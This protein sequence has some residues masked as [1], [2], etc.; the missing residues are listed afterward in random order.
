MTASR[1]QVAR[2]AARTSRWTLFF[3]RF[4]GIDVF[5]HASL[6]LLVAVLGVAQAVT[7]GSI[8]AA[9]AS[10]LG[11]AA[12]FACVLLHEYGHALAARR[13]GIE[14]H[15][16]LL[17]PIGGVAQLDRMP[18]RPREELIVALA[19]PAVNLVIAAVTGTALIA[20]ALI[21]PPFAATITGGLVFLTAI[22]LLLL[23]FNLLPAFPMDGG[24]A[25]RAVLA[26]RMRPLRATEI[27]AK[28]GQFMAVGMGIVG[29][30]FNPLLAFV[31]LFVWFGAGKEVQF[32]RMQ[33]R[34]SGS[35]VESVMTTDFRTLS[36]TDRL[37][38][39]ADLS[40]RSAQGAFPVLHDG[41][42]VGMLGTERLAR[43]LAVG[44]VSSVSG[45][46]RYD[47][48]AVHPREQLV[49]A[50]TRLATNGQKALPVLDGARLVGLVTLEGLQKFLDLRPFAQRRSSVA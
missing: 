47:F 42:V 10:V 33:E 6:L 23:V 34:L 31:A 36:P 7:T 46:M 21:A 14:T 44:E 12:I 20:T 27:A 40:V 32:A 19:G 16:I 25:L 15:R 48:E 38:D 30:F 18:D 28:T 41:R 24:R 45:A 4:L 8:V 17:L 39:V 22:N 43:A 29:L 50:F 35:W 3:G 26:M 49:N 1:P 11:I 13:F 5:V 37:Q 2:P 9:G